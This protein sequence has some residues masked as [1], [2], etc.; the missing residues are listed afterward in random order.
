MNDLSAEEWKMTKTRAKHVTL[1]SNMI[2]WHT[3][4][5]WNVLESPNF[6][7]RPTTVSFKLFKGPARQG[8]ESEVFF[9]WNTSQT[10]FW[11]IMYLA[12]LSQKYQNGILKVIN[13]CFISFINMWLILVPRIDGSNY[14]QP[15]HSDAWSK[16]L[17]NDSFFKPTYL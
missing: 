8:D 7:N 4:P 14:F 16:D 9:F 1:F 6:K 2:P 3:R 17:L 13:V 10:N 5:K 15:E 11:P 12:G